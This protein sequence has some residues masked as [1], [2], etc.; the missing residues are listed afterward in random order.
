MAFD[1]TSQST[2]LNSVSACGEFLLAG[3]SFVPVFCPRPQPPRPA[4]LPQLRADCQLV[5]PTWLPLPVL[6]GSQ[7]RNALPRGAQNPSGHPENRP[8][9]G[10]SS[11]R[12]AG[13][14]RGGA[15]R[16]GEDKEEE[17]EGRRRMMMKA[18]APAAGMQAGTRPGGDRA[19]RGRG[20]GKGRPQA[21]RGRGP[22]AQPRELPA[23]PRLPPR[24]GTEPP[25]NRPPSPPG[26]APSAPHLGASEGRGGPPALSAAGEGGGAGEGRAKGG[27]P[28]HASLLRPGGKRK[29]RGKEERKRPRP[30]EGAPRCAPHGAA[31]TLT[32]A[33]RS[34][35]GPAS[36]GEGGESCP[37]ITERR[38]SRLPPARQSPRTEPAP[39]RPPAVPIRRLTRPRANRRGGRERPPWRAP[40]FSLTQSLRRTPRTERFGSS[41][42]SANQSSGRNPRRPSL[43]L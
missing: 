11:Q 6:C 39:A 5:I 35:P 17:E 36:A 24:F 29:E 34:A 2:A 14:R 1:P 8:A 22:T 43:S 27:R 26:R 37:P 9:L 23:Q 38:G 32:E 15:R 13:A 4:A 42:G 21:R 30:E 19:A 20:E 7:G 3:L 41:A 28:H 33:R 31:P 10:S 16:P 25:P 18:A 12:A 40:P